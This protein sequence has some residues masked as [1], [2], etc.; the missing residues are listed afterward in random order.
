MGLMATRSSTPDP[1]P[2]PADDDLGAAF[3]RG[4]IDLSELN[5]RASEAGAAATAAP[6]GAG[7]LTPVGTGDVAPSDT[8]SPT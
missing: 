1:A 5:R 2:T 4:D 7:G 6:A 3:R 8:P